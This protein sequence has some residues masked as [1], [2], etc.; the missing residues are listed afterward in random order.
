M[1]HFHPARLE[2]QRRRWSV[3]DAFRQPRLP[4]RYLRPNHPA[5]AKPSTS[6]FSEMGGSPRAASDAKSACDRTW[7]QHA[8]LLRLIADIRFEQLRHA[9]LRAKH[10]AE[11]T[12]KPD[13]P[14]VPAGAPDG[15]QWTGQD[16]AAFD[17]GRGG[18]PTDISAA[19]RGTAALCAAQ[20]AA[21]IFHCKMVGVRACYAQATERFAACLAGRP[22][23]PLNY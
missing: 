13:Q 7:H 6:H 20:Y 21:D 2:Y 16:A 5:L 11:Q 22:I 12:Y 9:S 1:T 8:A 14:R 10:L 17:N 3:S 18:S 4:D 15:G 19:K 23:P